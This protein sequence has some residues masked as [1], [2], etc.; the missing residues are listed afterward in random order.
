M[1]ITYINATCTYIRI[2]T[3]THTHRYIH[4]YIRIYAYMYITHTN[5]TY[6]YIR[7]HTYTHTHR[8]IHIYTVS[9]HIYTYQP[10]MYVTFIDITFLRKSADNLRISNF[11]IY[12]HFF[13]HTCVY[14]A[15]Q[16]SCICKSQCSC[17][18]N[19]QYI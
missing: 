17:T 6:M 2:H 14:I 7:I 16:W 5:A 13:Q 15:F 10:F 19:F 3:Y 9:V 8:Y 18:C 12:V 4:I 1:Y 11:Y